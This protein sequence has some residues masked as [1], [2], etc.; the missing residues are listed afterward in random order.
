M[1]TEADWRQWK[2]A[3]FIPYLDV[4][5]EAFGTKRIMYG[6]D[7]PVCL[8]AASYKRMKAIVDAYFKPFTE[9]E[10]KAFY[11]GNATGFYNLCPLI[12]VILNSFGTYTLCFSINFPSAY[13]SKLI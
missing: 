9:N 3:D 6:S 11:G 5:V 10:R 8:V 12:P 13:S 7:W 2:P 1:V 4:I